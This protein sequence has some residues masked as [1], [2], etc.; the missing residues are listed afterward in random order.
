M[1]KV[2]RKNNNKNNDNNG[3]TMILVIIFILFISMAMKM[4]IIIV[5]MIMIIIMI[6]TDNENDYDNN[7]SV[8]K[9]DFLVDFFSVSS[10]LSIHL[11]QPRKEKNIYILSYHRY[12]SNHIFY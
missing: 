2:V 7:D 10:R 11:T 5:F 9:N 12:S 8:V 1:N 4:L 3:K 6:Y